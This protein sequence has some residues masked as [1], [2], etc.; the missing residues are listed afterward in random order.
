MVNILLT[1]SK[2][3]WTSLDAEAAFGLC[4]LWYSL[5]SYHYDISKYV[6]FLMQNRIQTENENQI[7]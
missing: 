6:T 4:L 2:F 1:K 5:Y 7:A 3:S